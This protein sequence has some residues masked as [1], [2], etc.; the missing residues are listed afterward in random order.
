MEDV[1]CNR[2]EAFEKKTELRCIMEYQLRGCLV[3]RTFPCQAF[4]FRFYMIS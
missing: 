3:M 2:N 4:A 1:Y